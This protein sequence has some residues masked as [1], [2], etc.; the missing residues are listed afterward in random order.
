MWSC[1]SGE[2]GGF[3]ILSRRYSSSSPRVRLMVFGSLGLFTLALGGAFAVM[4]AWP[5]APFA[6]IECVALYLVYRWLQRHDGDY[7]L[8]VIDGDEVIVRSQNGATH[9]R[10]RLSRFWAQVV[11]EDRPVGRKRVFL[12]SHGRDVEIGR[13][14]PDEARLS[15]ARRLR[16]RISGL[17]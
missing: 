8:I 17:V 7:E 13:L 10:R 2:D 6:G 14:L 5:V 4:G 16:K 15:V 3:E 12:R 11:V 1:A 9:E